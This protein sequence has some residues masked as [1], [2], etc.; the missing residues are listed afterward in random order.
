MEK[1]SRLREVIRERIGRIYPVEL[2][3][4]VYGYKSKASYKE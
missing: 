1:I 3:C 4:R 2:R